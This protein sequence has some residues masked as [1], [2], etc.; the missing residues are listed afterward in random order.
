MY[1]KGIFKN[2]NN[3]KFFNILNFKKLYFK[4]KI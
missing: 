1:I 4:M 3:S 2:D